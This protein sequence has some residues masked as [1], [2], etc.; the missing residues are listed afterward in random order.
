[1][2]NDDDVRLA[3]RGLRSAMRSLSPVQRTELRRAARI[4]TRRLIL[5]KRVEAANLLRVMTG[6]VEPERQ[7]N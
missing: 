7:S 4:Q 6:T 5:D 1:M 2:W 3:I